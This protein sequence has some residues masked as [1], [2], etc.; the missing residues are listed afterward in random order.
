MYKSMMGIMAI[1]ATNLSAVGYA[2]STEI[3]ADR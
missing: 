3:D 2:G 1:A